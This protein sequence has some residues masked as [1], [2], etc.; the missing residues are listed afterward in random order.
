MGPHDPSHNVGGR[1]AMNSGLMTDT[2]KEAIFARSGSLNVDTQP[3]S[4]RHRLGGGET[5]LPAATVRRPVD[6]RNCNLH[7]AWAQYIQGANRVFDR[8][9]DA[10]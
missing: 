10:S 7:F 2:G 3:Q 9:I 8:R 1:H 6:L 4:G 5:F